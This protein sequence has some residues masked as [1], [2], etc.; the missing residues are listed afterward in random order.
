MPDL[1]DRDLLCRRVK[2]RLGAAQVAKMLDL[3]AG[4][5]VLAIQG[6]FDPPSIEVIVVHPDLPMVPLDTEA[7]PVGG[8]VS[9]ERF[10]DDAGRVWHRSIVTWR[11]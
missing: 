10:A 9:V 3:P 8:T 5:E 4:T 6:T 1:I 11:P 7:P 2:V